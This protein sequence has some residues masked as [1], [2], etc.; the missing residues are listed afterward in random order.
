MVPLIKPIQEC[1]ELLAE[2]P[3]E[4][5]R[6]VALKG[7][8][9]LTVQV[10]TL[11]PSQGPTPS[12][13]ART[14]IDATIPILVIMVTDDES[15]DV[16]ASGL[17]A[18]LSVITTFKGDVFNDHLPD[19][20]RCI[21]QVLQS[22]IEADKYP[23]ADTEKD[24]ILDSCCDLIGGLP[25]A[26]STE[27]SVAMVRELWAPLGTRFSQGDALTQAL[28][29][30]ALG[31]AVDAL[32]GA[33]PSDIAVL[34]IAMQA[35]ASD[36]CR[37]R[38]NAAFCAGACFAA[39][40]IAPQDASRFSSVLLD[41]LAAPIPVNDDHAMAAVDNVC[42]ALCKL[43]AG[44]SRCTFDP[45]RVF[46]AVIGA[47]PLKVRCFGGLFMSLQLMIF[48]RLTWMNADLSTQHWRRRCGRTFLRRRV[49]VQPPTPWSPNAPLA[50]ARPTPTK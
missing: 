45:L 30:G 40:G 42:S 18:L 37:L 39:S 48:C 29:I 1:F 26:L 10:G 13:E 3:H 25:Q 46:E 23:L 43:V 17:D 6:L 36:H 21:T 38:R 47:C 7:L 41:L 28:I 44:P 19:I 16:V 35:L 2:Y 5:M 34:P 9:D 33:M 12:E 4:N 14:M 50:S 24:S 49:P 27:V 20:V 15:R 22:T 8:H 32:Q 31:E 11:Y